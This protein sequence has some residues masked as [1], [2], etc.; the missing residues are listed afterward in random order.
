MKPQLNQ[1]MLL[2]SSG[3]QGTTSH[4]SQRNVCDSLYK[5]KLFFILDIIIQHRVSAQCRVVVS[6]NLSCLLTIIDWK[7]AESG[8]IS[9]SN[10]L[11]L[12]ANSTSGAKLKE[13]MLYLGCSVPHA[14]LKLQ[15]STHMCW[16]ILPNSATQLSEDILNSPADIIPQCKLGTFFWC[17]YL[18]TK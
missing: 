18:L 16:Q 5:I 10:S 8:I 11:F 6:G 4:C 7:M 3:K 2:F 9:I 15:V 14:M 1:A 12:Q 17:Y 13:K